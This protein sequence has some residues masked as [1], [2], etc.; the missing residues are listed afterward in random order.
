MIL[1]WQEGHFRIFSGWGWFHD[2]VSLTVHHSTVFKPSPKR[3]LAA[4][5]PQAQGQTDFYP[6]PLPPMLLATYMA[7]SLCCLFLGFSL[8]KYSD[9]RRQRNCPTP[10]MMNVAGPEPSISPPKTKFVQVTLE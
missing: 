10:P 9:S 5:K 6:H 1:K 8:S 3:P 4:L 7:H 2:H